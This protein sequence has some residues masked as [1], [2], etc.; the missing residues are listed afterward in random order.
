MGNSNNEPNTD[1]LSLASSAPLWSRIM[2]DVS[3]GLPMADW[4]LPDGIQIATVDAFS[5]MKPGS[6]SSK[7]VK[8][9]FIE[10]TVP[11]ETDDLRR[12]VEIDTATGDLWQEGCL[13]PRKTVAALDFSRAEEAFPEWGKFTRGWAKRAA[14]GAGRAGGPEGNRTSYFYGGGFYPYGRTWGGIFAPTELCSPPPPRNDC[15][16]PAASAEPAVTCPPGNNGNG[17]GNGN[18][19]KPTPKP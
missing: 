3:A 7:T 16:E 18:G 5:G 8:E 12:S 14:G 9:L 1:A 11:T 19:N 13:G 6:G 10:G 2:R 4:T 17:N 15:P